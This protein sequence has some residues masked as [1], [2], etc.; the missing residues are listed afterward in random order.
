MK[1]TLRYLAVL[2]IL[3]ATFVPASFAD[4]GSGTHTCPSGTCKPGPDTK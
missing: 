2:A 1:K 4:G 3:T